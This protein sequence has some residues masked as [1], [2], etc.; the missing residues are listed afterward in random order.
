[1][2]FT[3]W[4]KSL[5]DVDI[6]WNTSEVSVT[7]C[8]T[9]LCEVGEEESQLRTLQLRGSAVSY[10]SIKCLLRSCPKLESIDLQS[11]RGLPR[12]IKRSYSGQD[13]YTLKS[14]VFEGKYD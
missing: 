7:C 12:G 6:S 4:S 2:A 5:I 10:E 1:M 13:F 3:K 8:M 9:S 14:E 11:C